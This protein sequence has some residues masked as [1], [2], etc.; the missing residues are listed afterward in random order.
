ML[1]LLKAWSLFGRRSNADC[2][3]SLREKQSFAERKTTLQQTM[4]RRMPS[5][6]AAGIILLKAASRHSVLATP[7]FIAQMETTLTEKASLF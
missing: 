3:C 5:R 7:F 6:T 1:E 2:R 4:A